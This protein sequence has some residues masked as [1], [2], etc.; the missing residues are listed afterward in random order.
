[1]TTPEKQAREALIEQAAARLEGWL[2]SSSPERHEA[3]PEA[4]TDLLT[5]LRTP[6]EETA[7]GDER[8][9]P[10]EPFG[11]TTPPVDE[12]KVR[13][14]DE[15]VKRGVDALGCFQ[16]LYVSRS[17]VAAI[18]KAALSPAPAVDGDRQ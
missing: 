11:I 14:T 10:R 17:E 18:I 5:A 6:A 8:I 13:V 9:Y 1:M 4:A 3:I 7:I 16:Q 15:M 12:A 2:K